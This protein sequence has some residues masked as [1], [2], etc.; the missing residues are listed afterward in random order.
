MTL[1]VTVTGS[2]AASNSVAYRGEPLRRASVELAD[3][4]LADIGVRHLARRKPRAA[5]IGVAGHDPAFAEGGGQRLD[6][7]DAVLQ[8]Q[9]E[10]LARQDVR[11]HRRDGRG[12]VAVDHD[13]RHVD[14]ADRRRVG[15]RGE[16]R[17]GGRRHVR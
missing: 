3:R 7:A 15:G 16:A 5:V 6:I 12:G 1:S 9:D 8:R 2:P 11:E 4:G 10:G 13:Q 14:R 17:G